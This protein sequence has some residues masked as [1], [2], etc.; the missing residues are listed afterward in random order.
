MPPAKKNSAPPAA[1]N[2][3]EKIETVIVTGDPRDLAP[4]E[5]NAR[6]MNAQQFK[7]L[8]DNIKRDGALTSLPLVYPKGD[9]KIIVSGNHRTKAAIAAGLTEISW[10]EVVGELTE[11]R[12]VALQLAHN[13]ITGDDDPNILKDLYDALPVLE[14]LYSGLTDASFGGIEA[15]DLTKLAIGTPRYRE[16][17]LMFLEEDRELFIEL[18]EGL[19]KRGKDLRRFHAPMALYQKFENT[20]VAVQDS[21]GIYNQALSVH[22][23]IELAAERLEQLEE[24]MRVDGVEGE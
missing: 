2:P 23:M 17:S 14:K 7:R 24:A 12:F 1:S 6:R 5:K 20:L 21:L 22:A 19:A 18:F 3:S 13:A 10:L 9:K 15:L 8:V 16:I 11:E 4:L